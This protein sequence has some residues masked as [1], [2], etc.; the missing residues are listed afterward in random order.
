[1]VEEG[2][3]LPPL[4]D[5]LFSIVVVVGVVVGILYVLMNEGAADKIAKNIFTVKGAIAAFVVYVVVSAIR[6]SIQRKKLG[7]IRP[8]N[9]LPLESVHRQMGVGVSRRC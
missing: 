3:K 1:M 9:D 5:W 8:Q 7:K 6:A 2:K 4:V